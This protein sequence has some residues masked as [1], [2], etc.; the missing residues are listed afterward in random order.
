M[1]KNIKVKILAG[2]V[3]S[4][5]Q[6]IYGRKEME[7][8]MSFGAENEFRLAKRPSEIHSTNQTEE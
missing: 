7:K 1:F 6:M 3:Q 5:Q 8:R 2:I 4:K